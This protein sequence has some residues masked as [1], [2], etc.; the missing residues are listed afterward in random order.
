MSTRATNKATDQIIIEAGKQQEQ[1]NNQQQPR[2]QQTTNTT[3]TTKQHQKGKNNTTRAQPT[4]Q[5]REIVDVPKDKEETTVV[6][7]KKTTVGDTPSY[8]EPINCFSGCDPSTGE[9]KISVDPTDLILPPL[10]N[11]TVILIRHGEKPTSDAPNQEDLCCLGY[12]RSQYLVDFFTGQAPTSPLNITWNIQRII[13]MN[14]FD[15]GS[16][17]PY[18]TVL[19]LAA[20]LGFINT[21]YF[22]AEVDKD[23]IDGVCSMITAAPAGCTLVCWEHDRLGDIAKQLNANVDFGAGNGSWPDTYNQILILNLTVPQIIYSSEYFG[24][25]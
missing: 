22:N 1:T 24:T 11:S 5:K 12:Q 17:R 20:K 18:K 8:P 25:D 13:A 23:D 6:S 2:K 14:P 16:Q 3:N 19:P 7:P 9:P 15:N 4:A 10:S 21:S